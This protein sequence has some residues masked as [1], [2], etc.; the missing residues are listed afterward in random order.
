ILHR[1]QPLA[2]RVVELVKRHQVRMNDV[3]QPA[4]LAL[5]AIEICAGGLAEDLECNVCPA[6]TIMSEIDDAKAARRELTH[7]LKSLRPARVRCRENRIHASP[8]T[9]RSGRESDHLTTEVVGPFVRAWG[10]DEVGKICGT[11]GEAQDYSATSTE[12]VKM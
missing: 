12:A 4:E 7:D 10:S 8:H 1:E 11:S 9:P 5:E 3:R 6:A 2:S